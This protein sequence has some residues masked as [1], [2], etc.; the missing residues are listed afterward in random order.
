M[1]VQVSAATRSSETVLATQKFA[2]TNPGK[3]LSQGEGD[4]RTGRQAH[5]GADHRRTVMFI[6]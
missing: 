6:E 4:D 3:F 2:G 1:V 5:V